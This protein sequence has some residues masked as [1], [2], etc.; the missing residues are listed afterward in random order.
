MRLARANRKADLGSFLFRLKDTLRGVNVAILCREFVQ[1][2]ESV[3][4]ETEADR[5]RERPERKT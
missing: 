2:G 5:V 3:A 4:F 1:L